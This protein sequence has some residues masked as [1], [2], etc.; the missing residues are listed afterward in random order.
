MKILWR[1]GWKKFTAFAIVAGLAISVIQLVKD[2]G[3][4]DPAA[5]EPSAIIEPVE[6]GS[7]SLEPCTFVRGT[8]VPASGMTLVLAVIPPAHVRARA[9]IRFIPLSP[10]EGQWSTVASLTADIDIPGK[11]TIMLIAMETA[12][13]HFAGDIAGHSWWIAQAMPPDHER[14]LISR[15]VQRG[16]GK[17]S[18]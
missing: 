8:G 6:D 5:A 18:C 15:T 9:G 10:L 11:F 4:T 17:A 14:A 1:K 12:L 2:I 3:F 16:P 7:Q 13:V